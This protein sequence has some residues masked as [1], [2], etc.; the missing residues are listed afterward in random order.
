MS[1]LLERMVRR[2]HAPLSS[3]E[4]VSPAHFADQ[5]AAAG[6]DDATAENV[7][8]SSE[9]AARTELPHPVQLPTRPQP[10]ETIGPG[11][12]PRSG[13]APDT[14][15]R[16]DLPPASA[17]SPGR[18]LR[19]Y[20]GLA[21]RPQA[22]HA[23]H[24]QGPPAVGRGAPAANAETEATLAIPSV[25]VAAR[26][27]SDRPEP[28]SQRSGTP[29]PAPQR[30][31]E[32]GDGPAVTISI[33]HIEVRAAPPI[34]PPRPRPQFKPRVSLEDFLTQRQDRRR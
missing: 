13:S 15:P 12:R 21:A 28:P 25:S 2:N 22:E 20:P 5:S 16:H 6:W 24:E 7:E 33:G 18:E 17:P 8:T 26:A 30:S 32:S 23:T 27:V 9:E 29:S 14:T 4:P 34:E 10:S 3:L 31:A 19:P 11:Q 1:T